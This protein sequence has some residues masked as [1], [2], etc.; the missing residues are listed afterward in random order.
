MG[1]LGAAEMPL[2]G[3]SAH[4]NHNFLSRALVWSEGIIGWSLAMKTDT[5]DNIQNKKIKDFESKPIC[6]LTVFV[7][8]R[9]HLVERDSEW[10]KW[11]AVFIQKHVETA[12]H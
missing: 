12:T 3:P 7:M 10:F 9:V 6:F 8:N 11:R 4:R 1:P 2:Q 5:F